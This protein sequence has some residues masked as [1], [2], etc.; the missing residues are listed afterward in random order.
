MAKAALDF[1]SLTVGLGIITSQSDA[2]GS[3]TLST[4][5][6]NPVPWQA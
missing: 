5:N 6:N 2:V 4:S 3:G 1:R